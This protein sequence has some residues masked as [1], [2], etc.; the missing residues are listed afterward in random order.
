MVTGVPVDVLWVYE[1]SQRNG[2][3]IE[4]NSERCGGEEL[5][6]LEGWVPRA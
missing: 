3:G 1:K 2:D 6:T 4:G 5:S